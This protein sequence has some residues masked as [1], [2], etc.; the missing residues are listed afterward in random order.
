MTTAV[1][2]FFIPTS[3]ILSE[4]W[5]CYNINKSYSKIMLIARYWIGGGDER[6]CHFCAIDT[7]N[8]QQRQKYPRYEIFYILGICKYIVAGTTGICPDV[9]PQP[10]YTVGDGKVNEKER[11]E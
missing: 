5:C 8:I 6:V 1:S 11:N 7:Q 3:L 10:Y 2:I 9:Q 4:N